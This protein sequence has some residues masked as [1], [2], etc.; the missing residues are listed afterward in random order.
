[1]NIHRAER[2]ADP[3]LAVIARSSRPGRSRGL[4]NSLEELEADRSHL[5]EAD[6]RPRRS[7]LPLAAVDI[8]G[9]LHASTTGR[10]EDEHPVLRYSE[11][12]A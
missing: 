11:V 4:S 9:S 10:T 2:V 3:V 7:A 1:V 6:H 8:P 5:I 12:D